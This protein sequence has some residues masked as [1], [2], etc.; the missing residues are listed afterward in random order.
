ML[1]AQNDSPCQPLPT[2]LRSV[3]IGAKSLLRALLPVLK[4]RR[5]GDQIAARAWRSRARTS[6]LTV[7][8]LAERAIIL[9]D[10]LPRETRCLP[11]SSVRE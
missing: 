9:L 8:L 5:N 3:L 7:L 1:L 10:A 2:Q 6:V 11:V 4:S